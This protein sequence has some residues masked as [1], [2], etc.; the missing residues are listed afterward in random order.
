MRSLADMADVTVRVD[1]AGTGDWHIGR[2]PDPRTIAVAAAHGADISAYRARRIA[3]AD[4]QDF[5]HIVAL[6]RANLRDI[7][8]MRPAAA[9][10]TISLLLDHVPGR[11]GQDVADPYMGDAAAFEKAW[12]DIHAGVAAMLNDRAVFYR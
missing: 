9:K 11:E 4:F 7:T 6:D 1:S 5:D 3:P 8:A 12:Q 10:A 2:P